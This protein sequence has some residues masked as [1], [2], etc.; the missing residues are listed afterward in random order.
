MHL[1]RILPPR[2]VQEF[3]PA[4]ELPTTPDHRLDLG[5]SLR[6]GVF[7][8]R[9]PAPTS[10]APRSPCKFFLARLFDRIQAQGNPPAANIM[11]SNPLS[12]PLTY[13]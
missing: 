6:H 3:P 10:P 12:S 4:N 2:S 13:S 8:T 7:E 9:T 5:C 1:I 11:K